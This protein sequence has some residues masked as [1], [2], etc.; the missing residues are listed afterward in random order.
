M[1]APAIVRA[2]VSGAAAVLLGLHLWF[3]GYRVDF[4][5]V[6]LLVVAVLPWLHHVFKDI[7]VSTTGI[8]ITYAATQRA[9]DRAVAGAERTAGQ[10]AGSS[11]R[12][13]D[14]PPGWQRVAADDPN[15]ALVGL[16]I[17]IEQRLRALGEKHG[18]R[19]KNLVALL[20][21]LGARGV[22]DGETGDGLRDLI[23]AGNRAAH[24]AQVDAD[25]G[26][27]LSRRVPLLLAALDA[28]LAR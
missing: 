20:D 11:S 25:L 6:A 28:L 12:S 18:V 5:T 17:E 4:V 13:G 27:L 15:L 3:P 21:E 19:S 23:L 2:V 22:I 8:E 1:T 7:K 26:H 16:R 14:E 9:L 24:G 10:P